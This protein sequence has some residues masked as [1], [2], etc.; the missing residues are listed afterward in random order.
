MLYRR[1]G[2]TEIQM[3]VFSAGMMRSMASWGDM[4]LA[5]I[6]ADEQA[7]LQAIVDKALSLGINHIETARAYGSSEN[8]LGRVL[9]NYPRNEI[10]VQTKVIPEADPDLFTAK[11]LDS[12]ARLNLDYLDLLALHGINDHRA[13]WYCCRKNGCLA[14][15]RKLQDQGK[16]RHI[17]FSGHGHAEIIRE[18]IRHQEDGGFDYM[19]IHWYYIV[20]QSWPLI[21]EAHQRDMGVFIISP[22]DKGGMLHTP[23]DILKKLSAPLSPMQFNDLFCLSKPEIST[24]SIGASLPDHFE[25]HLQGL[26]S[27]NNALLL[28]NIDR[29]WRTAMKEAIG[30]EK[31][32]H[33]WQQ[34]PSWEETPGLI[35]IPFIL[36]LLNLAEGW[37]LSGYAQARYRKLG[38]EMPWVPGRDAKGLRQFDFSSFFRKIPLD[39]A[40]TLARLEL[41]HTLFSQTA[42]E[43]CPTLE[44]PP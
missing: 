32:D 30:H 27:L 42:N 24:I 22:T 37:G 13:F 21:V 44:T 12:L 14:A 15:A 28:D 35:N 1:F 8:Q 4:P 34:I 16:I 11:V 5:M 17:G 43:I 25:A 29:K 18:A 23:P 20:Q 33:H 38:Q 10:V 41:A 26:G 6:A 31:P 39:Q 36:W 19:N 7:R 40:Q 9:P 2:K 3:P